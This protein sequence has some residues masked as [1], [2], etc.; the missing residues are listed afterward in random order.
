[1]KYRAVCASQIIVGLSSTGENSRHAWN[2]T[3]A[4]LLKQASLFF[5]KVIG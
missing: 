1:M 2:I 3:V 5:N 4:A